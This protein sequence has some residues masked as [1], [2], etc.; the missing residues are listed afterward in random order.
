MRGFLATN[1]NICTGCKACT[2]ACSLSHHQICNPALSRVHIMKW[3]AEGLDVPVVCRQC[4]KA[5]CAAA[6]P[7][8]AR[9][10]ASIFINSVI[11]KQSCTS[12]IAT[13]EAERPAAW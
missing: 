2:L 13:S 5:P 6:C 7:V 1:H 10:R 8:G 12:A 11:V 9:P 3:T 4:S